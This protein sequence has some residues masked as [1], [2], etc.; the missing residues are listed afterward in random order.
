VGSHAIEVRW[1]DGALQTFTGI[2]AGRTSVLKQ[3][4]SAP[5]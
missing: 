1:P 2:A 5:E 4:A 3:G